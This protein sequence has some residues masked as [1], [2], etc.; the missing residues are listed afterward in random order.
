MAL[1]KDFLAQCQVVL[2]RDRILAMKE[3]QVRFGEEIAIVALSR[4]SR[5]GYGHTR[6]REPLGN[7]RVQL[8]NGKKILLVHSHCPSPF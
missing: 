8:A 7:P 2:E 1:L 4:G 3:I 5:V 6:A